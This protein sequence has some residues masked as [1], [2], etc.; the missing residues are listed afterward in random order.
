MHPAIDDY[1]CGLCDGVHVCVCVSAYTP[2][3]GLGLK[4][5]LKLST[6]PAKHLSHTKT[7]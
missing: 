7:H 2:G 4:P 1:R 6:I 3:I 5:H